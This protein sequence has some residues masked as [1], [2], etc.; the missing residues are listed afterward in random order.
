M[1]K[2]RV[3]L[4]NAKQLV[5]VINMISFICIDGECRR[6]DRQGKVEEIYRKSHI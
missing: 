1:E 2:C 3:G 5:M 4:W 6:K